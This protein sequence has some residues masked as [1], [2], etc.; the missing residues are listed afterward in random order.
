MVAATAV[1]VTAIV[2]DTRADVV[3]ATAVAVTAT[4]HALVTA[5]ALN[6]VATAAAA[7][8]GYICVNRPHFA[9]LLSWA[10]FV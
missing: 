8:A 1:A 2:V 3:A 5:A 7:A 10:L 4:S 9:G 6:R